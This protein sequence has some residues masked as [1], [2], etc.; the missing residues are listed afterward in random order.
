MR[1]KKIEWLSGEE[2][3]KLQKSFE[4]KN[5]PDKDLYLELSYETGM[6]VSEILGY[7]Q[8][9][10]TSD[11]VK[12]SVTDPM[13]PNQILYNKKEDCHYIRV[14][15]KG[16]KTRIVPLGEEMHYKLKNY[17]DVYSIGDGDNIFDFSVSTAQRWCKLGS[18]DAGIKHVHP[19]MLRHTYAVNYLMD[20]GNIR[21]LQAI[22]GH[23]ELK[24]TARYLQVANILV[25]RDHKRTQTIKHS[26]GKT[27]KVTGQLCQLC[28]IDATV[29]I[30]VADSSSLLILC[31]RCK[32]GYV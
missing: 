22:L 12:Q 17:I 28:G 8:V 7:A 32:R 3:K 11:Q 16:G 2:F 13:K 23:E 24:T 4:K 26:S 29:A 6:R 5:Q 1:S 14:V 15:G 31:D 19:H 25:M 27:F 18:K 9:Y 30:P 21:A 20:G 10:R